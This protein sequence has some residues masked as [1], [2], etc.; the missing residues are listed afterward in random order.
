VPTRS[1]YALSER[2]HHERVRRRPLVCLVLTHGEVR[3]MRAC[4]RS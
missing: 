3:R 2:G 1:R 4:G